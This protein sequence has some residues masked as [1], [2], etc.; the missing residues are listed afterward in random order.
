MVAQSNKLQSTF[1]DKFSSVNRGRPWNRMSLTY[2]I[3]IISCHMDQIIWPIWY[4]SYHMS[5]VFSPQLD[6][7]LISSRERM[8]PK[9]RFYLF[10]FFKNIPRSLFQKCFWHF[11]KRELFDSIL[12][13][14]II[15][16]HMKILKN[17]QRPGIE[18]GPPAW[19]ARIL[20]LNQRCLLT[21]SN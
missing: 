13:W 5:Y 9:T 20:P 12:T 1:S 11:I 17:L 14:C 16:K 6:Q 10:S 18:P 2:I 19:Q 21:L 7:S 4:G 15:S 3:L 8:E